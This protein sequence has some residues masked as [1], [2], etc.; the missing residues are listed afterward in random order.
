MSPLFAS[1]IDISRKACLEQARCLFHNNYSRNLRDFE[2]V[3]GLS[4][5]DWS[6]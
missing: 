6:I 5:Q 1:K 3:S 2:K 4:I